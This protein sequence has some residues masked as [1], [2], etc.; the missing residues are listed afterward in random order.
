MVVFGNLDFGKVVALERSATGHQL[1]P[2]SPLKNFRDMIEMDG[3]PLSSSPEKQR[4]CECCHGKGIQ[5]TPLDIETRMDTSY[6]VGLGNSFGGR[7]MVET[8]SPGQSSQPASGRHSG[9]THRNPPQ[10]TTQLL[11]MGHC[12]GRGKIAGDS[13]DS[14]DHP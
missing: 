8:P 12:P 2:L 4:L 1:L 7:L 13:R 11:S 14:P 6:A 10:T 9:P 5:L 3:N